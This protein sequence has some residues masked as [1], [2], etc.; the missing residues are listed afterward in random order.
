MDD[1]VPADVVADGLAQPTMF[2][3]RTAQMM[4]LERD[5]SG[6]WSEHDIAVTIGAM[7]AAYAKLTGGGYY[8]EISNI[9]H[10]NFTDLPYWLPLSDQLGLT[11]PIGGQHGFTVINAYTV[12]FFDS[13]LRGNASPLLDPASRLIPDATLQLRKPTTHD[14]RLRRTSGRPP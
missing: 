12:A 9:F 6:G 1:P 8:V 13:V 2:L 11:G 7:R 3:T 4:R 5:A 14:G 10:V